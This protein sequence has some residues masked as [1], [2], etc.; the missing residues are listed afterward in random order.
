VKTIRECESAYLETGKTVTSSGFDC[1][2][3]IISVNGQKQ[4]RVAHALPA[5]ELYSDRGLIFKHYTFGL[6][7]KTLGGHLP[8]IMSILKHLCGPTSKVFTIANMRQGSNYKG[9]W[10]DLDMVIE[11][12]AEHVRKD[13][14]R[15]NSD[16]LDQYRKVGVDLNFVLS[17]AV[18]TSYLYLS[19]VTKFDALVEHQGSRLLV[20]LNEGERQLRQQS[21]D[22]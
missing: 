19:R 3:L 15:G 21:I 7:P 6:L 16:H 14:K 17:T 1:C 12:L 22:L 9:T 13:A 4:V 20:T 10:R 11:R 5:D 2:A 8:E 18:Q